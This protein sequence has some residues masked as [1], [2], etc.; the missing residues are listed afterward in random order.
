MISGLP[1]SSLPVDVAEKIVAGSYAVLREGGAFM[2]YQFRPTARDLTEA[3]FERVDTGLALFNVPPCLLAWGW[4]LEDPLAAR[5]A[6][7]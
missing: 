2:T 3:R 7:E 6:A 1:F 5:E 4:K